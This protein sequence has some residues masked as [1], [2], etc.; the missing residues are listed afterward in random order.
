MINGL[1]AWP[2]AGGLVRHMEE[3]WR[4]GAHVHGDGWLVGELA[5]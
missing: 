1:Y 3:T 5:L 4:E 2:R